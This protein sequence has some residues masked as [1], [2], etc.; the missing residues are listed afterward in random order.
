MVVS[1]GC[2]DPGKPSKG[3]AGH[4]APV[5][6]R[7]PGSDGPSLQGSDV[8]VKMCCKTKPIPF[9]QSHP[10]RTAG[11]WASSLAIG[12]KLTTRLALWSSNSPNNLERDEGDGRLQIPVV[13]ANGP[14]GVGRQLSC[15]CN[16]GSCQPS[17]RGAVARILPCK[18]MEGKPKPKVALPQTKQFARLFE[19]LPSQQVV[20][21]TPTAT[22][23][24]AP[25]PTPVGQQQVAVPL[26]EPQPTWPLYLLPH[27]RSHVHTY[28]DQRDW[29]T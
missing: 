28:C 19:E 3:V 20:A 1:V 17:S 21:V 9:T 24:T 4:P 5:R 25:T 26:V 18:V 14:W 2:F 12:L 29:H 7:S 8:L 23:T 6:A 11:G 15:G 10:D 27:F 16:T 13:S 22:P